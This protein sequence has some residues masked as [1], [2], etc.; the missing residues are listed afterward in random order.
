VDN[1]NKIKNEFLYSL[2]ESSTGTKDDKEYPLKNILVYSESFKKQ[3]DGTINIDNIRSVVA[4]VVQCLY[5]DGFLSIKQLKVIA[6][7][8]ELTNIAD[9]TFQWVTIKTFLDKSGH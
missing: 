8:K 7:E 2:P 6:E 9:K 1:L 5:I 3:P 4:W